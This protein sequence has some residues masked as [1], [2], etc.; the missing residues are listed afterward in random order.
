[1]PPST[2]TRTPPLVH[3]AS[4]GYRASI[5]PAGAELMSLDHDGRPLLWP[6][7]ANSWAE[8]APVLFPTIGLVTNGEIRVDGRT[9][10]MPPHGF[11]KRSLFTVTASEPDRCTLTLEATAATREHYPFAFRLQLDYSLGAEGLRI[12]ATITNPGREALP[13]SFGFHPG[14]RWPLEAGVQKDSYT[15]RFADDRRLATKRPVQGF[16]TDES[17]VIDVPD[18]HLA[19]Q[20]DLFAGGGLFVVAPESSEVRFG[21]PAG[22]IA[23]RIAYKNCP[24]VMLWMKPGAGF[25][26]IEPWH[27][28]PDPA[29]FADDFKRKPGLATIPPGASTVVTMTVGVDE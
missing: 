27:G 13:A 9:Y 5:N 22:K 6:G 16:F 19:L 4:H 21:S 17:T 20:D 10:P 3:I 15:V 11:A 18:G 7:D 14:F 8:R 28:R 29:G 24:D 1:M 12:A 2:E 23:L 25:L 26:C